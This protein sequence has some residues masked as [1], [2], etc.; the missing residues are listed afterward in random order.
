M[1]SQY[2]T[3]QQ[4]LLYAVAL[5]ALGLL[6]AV[7]GTFVTVVGYPEAVEQFNVESSQKISN[8]AGGFFLFPWAIVAS[9]AA[10]AYQWF[11]PLRLDLRRGLAVGLSIAVVIGEFE[12][13]AL[14]MGLRD[15]EGVDTSLGAGFFLLLFGYFLA[16][17]AVALLWREEMAGGFALNLSVPPAAAPPPAAGLPRFPS[18]VVYTATADAPIYSQPNITS[19]TFGALRRGD[20][21]Q[22][23]GRGMGLVEVQLPGHQV[24]YVE[25]RFMMVAAPPP[26]PA[27]PPPATSPVAGSDQTAEMGV[28]PPPES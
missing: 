14:T 17:G 7:I 20:S 13:F 10:V 9:A 3:G 12:L 27:A 5:V 2:T 22:A 21:A 4:K 28:V 18:V 25:E 26:A 19:L 24:G 15:L 6:L 1:L 8:Q 11:R 16:L 23:L